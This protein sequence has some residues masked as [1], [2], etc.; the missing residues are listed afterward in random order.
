MEIVSKELPR[1]NNVLA[2]EILKIS[3]MP[4]RRVNNNHAEAWKHFAVKNVFRVESLL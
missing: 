1:N 2:T 4:P 3:G